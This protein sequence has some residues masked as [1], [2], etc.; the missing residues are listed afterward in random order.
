MC[1]FCPFDM[2]ACLWGAQHYIILASGCY[3]LCL[4]SD[5]G[6]LLYAHLSHIK[7]LLERESTQALHQSAPHSIVCQRKYMSSF[8]VRNNLIKIAIHLCLICFNHLC[9]TGNIAFSSINNSIYLVLFLFYLIKYSVWVFCCVYVNRRQWRI[10]CTGLE[11]QGVQDQQD[12]LLHYSASH[13]FDSHTS[14]YGQLYMSF[15][16]GSFMLVYHFGNDSIL[17]LLLQTSE[18]NT[19][20]SFHNTNCFLCVGEKWWWVLL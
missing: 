14:S 9:T 13:G 3:E 6:G 20:F 12:R 5:D 4:C 16:N 15:F 19:V 17:L 2:V 7:S 18:N 8:W 11:E 1:M 10:M